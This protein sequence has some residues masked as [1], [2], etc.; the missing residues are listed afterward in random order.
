MLYMRFG[1][2]LL[3]FSCMLSM[4]M[5][6]AESVDEK[7][8]E[9]FIFHQREWNR[10]LIAEHPDL[11]HSKTDEHWLLYVGPVQTGNEDATIRL[12]IAQG[13][14]KGRVLCGRTRNNPVKTVFFIRRSVMDQ[15]K[16]LY[17]DP[18]GIAA[19]YAAIGFFCASTLQL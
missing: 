19:W 4:C 11:V 10:A 2:L 3:S 18:E 14:L 7:A 15:F 16:D 8:V 1:V 13:C 12:H 9:R 17:R 6:N 5:D